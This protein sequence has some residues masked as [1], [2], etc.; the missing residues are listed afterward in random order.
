MLIVVLGGIGF[1]SLLGALNKL[2]LSL[3]FNSFSSSISISIYLLLP[4]PEELFP[5]VLKMSSGSKS[6]VL[7]TV[8]FF[9]F[10]KVSFFF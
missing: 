9:L 8:P 1:I 5:K 7:F 10:A 3:I 2:V 6:E 4:L